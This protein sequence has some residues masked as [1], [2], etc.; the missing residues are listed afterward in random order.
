[1][2]VAELE[3]AEIDGDIRNGEEDGRENRDARS[4]PAPRQ[5]VGRD[6]EQDSG[7]GAE[8][9]QAEQTRSRELHPEGHTPVVEVALTE[10]A[11]AERREVLAAH[12]AHRF[13]ARLACVSVHSPD[14]VAE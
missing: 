8:D 14:P 10:P 11:R 1:R 12:N 13:E 6:D 4:K 7:E 9:P 3:T 5:E 2:D